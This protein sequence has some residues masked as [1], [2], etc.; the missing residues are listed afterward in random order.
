MNP[1]GDMSLDPLVWCGLVVVLVLCFLIA[2]YGEE[3]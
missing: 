3:R 2:L 1:H